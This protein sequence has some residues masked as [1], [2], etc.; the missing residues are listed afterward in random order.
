MSFSL[1]FLLQLPSQ[2]FVLGKQ[3][4]QI[5]EHV[6]GQNFF[7]LPRHS[8]KECSD[9]TGFCLVGLVGGFFVLV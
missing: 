8:I 5:P 4:A 2:L 3:K 7:Q 1:P 9:K 6:N